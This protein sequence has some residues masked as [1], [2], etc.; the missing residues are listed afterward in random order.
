[1]RIPYRAGSGAVLVATGLLMVCSF[2]PAPPQNGI[3][4]CLWVQIAF[5]EKLA[6]VVWF[7]AFVI[8]VAVGL[9][10][11]PAPRWLS[12]AGAIALGVTVNHQLW[13]IEHCS[14]APYAVAYF[15]WAAMIGLMFL[16]HAMQPQAR[17]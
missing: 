8:H 2:L 9:R 16:H 1:M 3:G 13:R 17:A 14:A 12:I 6:G 4:N 11:L 10:N 15:I 7:G 5:A